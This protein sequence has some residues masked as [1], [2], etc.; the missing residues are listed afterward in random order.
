[1]RPGRIL[2]LLLGLAGVAAVAA[3]VMLWGPAARQPGGTTSPASRPTFV[4]G[5]TC[6]GCHAEQHDLWKGSDH[7]LAMQPAD[8]TTVLGDF[9]SKTF[10]KDGVTSTFFRRDGRYFVRTD[11]PDGALRDFEIAYTFGVDPLQQFLVP[12]ANGRYQAL[13][14]AWDSRPAATGGQRWFHMYPDEKI[15]HQDVLHWTGPLQSWS[16]MCADCHSTNLKKNYRP[17]EDRFEPRWTDIAVSCEA[18]H[19]PGSGHVLWAEHAGSG[20]PSPDP[21]RGFVFGLRDP[22]GGR[23]NL[24]PGESVA[25]RTTT[26]PSRAEVETCAPC[27]A[28]R[29]PIRSDP[30]PGE[31]LEQ[32]YRT[33]LLDDPLYHADGQIRDEVYEYGSFVQSPMYQAGVTCSDC[34]D[35]HSARLRQ[36]G[37]ALCSLC[38]L[39]AMY[40]GAQHHFHQAGTEAAQCVSCH[41]P[42]RLFMVVDGRRDHGFRIPRPDLTVKL[43]TP[44]ACNDC[45]AD[46]P[47][48]WAGEAVAA[49]YGPNRRGGWHWAEAIESGRSWRIDAQ[50]QLVRAILDPTVPAIARATALTL[51]P[52]YLGPGSLRAVEASLR[53]V[54]PLVRRSAA[55]NLAVLDPALRVSLGFPLLL[56][57]IRSVRF[58]ALSSL[59][60]TPGGALSDAQRAALD[61]VVLEAR[62]AWTS[63][64]DRVE[65]HL[66]LGSLD[67][68][69]GRLDA[70]EASYRTAIRLQP[71]FVPAYINLADLYRQQGREDRVREILEEALRR[72]PSAAEA[73]EAMG[74]SLVREK[75]LGDAI[76]LLEKAARLRES[77]PR[78]AYVHAVALYEV[79]EKQRAIEVLL[80]AHDRQPAHRDILAALVDYSRATGDGEAAAVWAGKLAELS[81]GGGE[82]GR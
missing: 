31:P 3:L 71:M 17:A 39:P 72:D 44:N 55:A 26:L 74:L 64:A 79:G 56:D 73:H 65:A 18:C 10:A 67:A 76:P 61:R 36:E 4:G 45:H 22:S 25:R 2:P 11:G 16:Y 80:G 46:R 20:H 30:E 35:P 77:E 27:H 60:E 63:L 32:S 78:Y 59:L 66:N 52:P 15:D 47:A 7:A 19:G 58:E 6:G 42:R 13:G 37:N 48:R 75:R 49:W 9:D 38:H 12:F 81:P 50:H 33:A 69:L 8:A 41:M 21:L 54:D 5:E 1:M 70:A 68:R 62:T 29:A 28:R 24:A 40:D 14:I 43:G 53:D 57:P 51:L 23:W 82:P 34:H